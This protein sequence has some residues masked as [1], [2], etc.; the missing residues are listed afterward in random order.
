MESGR[1]E[2]T[3]LENVTI[4]DVLPLKAARRDATAKLNWFWGP[5]PPAI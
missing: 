1:K 3:E 2:K 4:Q 5:G